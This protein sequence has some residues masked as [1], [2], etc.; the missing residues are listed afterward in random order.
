MPTDELHVAAPPLDP[1][2]YVWVLIDVA[3]AA[4]HVSE[5]TAL[6]IAATEGWRRSNK[7]S[8]RRPKTQYLW[9]DIVTTYTRRS[10]T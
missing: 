2:A 4:L 7:P 5:K 6:K 8:I 3:A 9:A 10:T 1:D